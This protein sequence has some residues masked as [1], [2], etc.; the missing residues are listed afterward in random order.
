[1]ATKKETTPAK[2][3]AVQQDETRALRVDWELVELVLD[4]EN[5]D[6]VL[7]W[8]PPGIGKSYAAYRMGQSRRGFY[9]IPLTQETAASEL[10][11]FF[12]PHGGELVWQDGP[13]VR[14]MREGAFLV[15]EELPE[16]SED[17]RAFLHALLDN[18][19]TARITLPTSE[20]VVPAPGF[21]V[22]ATSNLGPESLSPALRDRFDAMLHLTSP[23]PEGLARLSEPL[24]QVALRSFELPEE[25]AVSLRQ[26]LVLEKLQHEFGLPRACASVFGPERGAR[27]HDAI[28]LATRG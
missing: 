1:M 22:V 6:H 25:R 8:G 4:S 7:I 20:T 28:V 14:A 11:G 24:R 26:W 9:A 12:V 5:I 10:R 17:A 15:L 18:R 16:A 13:A 2:A 21:K 23:H 27:M 19:E 3:P